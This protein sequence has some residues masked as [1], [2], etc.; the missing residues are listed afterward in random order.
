VIEGSER[1][2]SRHHTEAE[3]AYGF[4]ERPTAEERAADHA[5]R[6]HAA[7]KQRPPDDA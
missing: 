6:R 3:I 2:L 7:E 1:E 4:S 5:L